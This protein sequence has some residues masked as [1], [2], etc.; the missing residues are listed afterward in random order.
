[1]TAAASA[2]LPAA[3]TV[4]PC[5]VVTSRTEPTPW[6]GQPLTEQGRELAIIRAGQAIERHMTAFQ[7]LEQVHNLT[8]CF[9]DIGEADRQHRMAHEAQ[10]LMVEL[11][12]GRSKAK[13]LSLE[14][15]AGL[16]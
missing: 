16:I 15:K 7:A 12:K 4:P 11:I 10:R 1:M 9:A 14:I 8:G 6:V 2:A 13:S 3:C 5:S